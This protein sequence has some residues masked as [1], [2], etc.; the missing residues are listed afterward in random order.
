MLLAIRTGA[1]RIQWDCNLTKLLWTANKLTYQT[2][3]HSRLR[4][5]R[6]WRTA[7][8]KVAVLSVREPCQLPAELPAKPH[9]CCSTFLE[10]YQLQWPAFF[11]KKKKKIMFPETSVSQLF[12]GLNIFFSF[13]FCGLIL[14]GFGVRRPLSIRDDPFLLH[15]KGTESWSGEG[16]LKSSIK[17]GMACIK[18]II[19]ALS[20]WEASLYTASLC[21]RGPI[22]RYLWPL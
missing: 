7:E 21:S 10:M 8:W 12:R 5:S 6:K 19:S 22:Q 16:N 17:F 13:S 1:G 9:R 18:E 4:M 11:L 3:T 14:S 2:V 20:L 15:W